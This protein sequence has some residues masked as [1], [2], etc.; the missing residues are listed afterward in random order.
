MTTAQA[1]PAAGPIVLD[2]RHASHWA[3]WRRP[4]PCRLCFG[5]AMLLDDGGRYCHKVC[6]EAKLEAERRADVV[7]VDQLVRAY[8]S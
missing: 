2:W 5:P 3:G 7:A 1:I 4:Q 6:A 8:R